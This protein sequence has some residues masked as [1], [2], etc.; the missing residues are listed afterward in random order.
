MSFSP[1]IRGEAV[2]L[3]DDLPVVRLVKVRHVVLAKEHLPRLILLFGG[4]K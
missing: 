3:V 4:G 2:V 1:A